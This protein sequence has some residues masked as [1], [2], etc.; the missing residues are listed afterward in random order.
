MRRDE[1]TLPWSF[2]FLLY[3]PYYTIVVSILFSII[4]ILWV[5]IIRII[6]FWGLHWGPSF[7]F[8]SLPQ[9][10][11]ENDSDQLQSP[12]LTSTLTTLYMGNLESMITRPGV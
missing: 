3:I 10:V 9:K 11:L 8:L 4:P 12:H 2:L 7:L 1:P 6:V 5:P